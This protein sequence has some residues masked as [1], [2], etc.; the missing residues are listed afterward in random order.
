MDIFVARTKPETDEDKKACEE[1]FQ[2]EASLQLTNGQIWSS[3]EDIVLRE[4]KR[5]EKKIIKEEANKEKEKSEQSTNAGKEKVWAEKASTS[6][7]A[8]TEAPTNGDANKEEAK[9]TQSPGNENMRRK[10]QNQTSRLM[11]RRKGW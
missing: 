3:W 5:Q 7:S 8:R 9:Q 1:Q 2:A 10:I 11:K 6:G 4:V